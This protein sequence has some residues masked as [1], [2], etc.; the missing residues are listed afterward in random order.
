MAAKQHTQ[1]KANPLVG[2][3]RLDGGG[4]EGREIGPEES[5]TADSDRQ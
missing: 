2:Q 4:E 1:A 5:Q 3:K